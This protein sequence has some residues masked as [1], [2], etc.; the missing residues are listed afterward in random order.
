MNPINSH[1]PMKEKKE[2][3]T[4]YSSY[5]TMEKTTI[6]IAQTTLEKLK[7]LKSYERQSYDELLNNLIDEQQEESLTQEEIIDIQ[8][9]LEDIKKGRVHSIEDVAKELGIQLKKH[10]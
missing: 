10:V 8:K 7:G 2:L 5:I 3:Y 1:S 4:S 6:Q 9:S